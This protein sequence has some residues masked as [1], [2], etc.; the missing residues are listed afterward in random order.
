MKSFTIALPEMR[1]YKVLDIAW[2]L[3][4]LVL[5]IVWGV[6]F[7]GNAE[8]PREINLAVMGV[9]VVVTGGF[10]LYAS[11]QQKA[12]RPLINRRFAE[13]F[14]AQTGH[15][16]PLDVDILVVK[17]SIAVRKDDGSVLLWSV[18]RSTGAIEVTPMTV[19]GSQWRQ[20]QLLRFP[21][22]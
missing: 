9:A 1:K 17:Q 11:R 2:R 10:V 7:F 8:G 20:F 16:Y 5:W 14:R 18:N 21:M 22:R 15:E 6:I 3:L 19:N 4:F 12:L 13:E